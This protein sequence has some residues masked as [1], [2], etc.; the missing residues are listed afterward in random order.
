MEGL[1]AYVLTENQVHDYAQYYN[2]FQGRTGY[3]LLVFRLQERDVSKGPVSGRVG[4][5][6]AVVRINQLPVRHEF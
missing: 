1:R 4:W 2:F 5:V 6:A 3:S